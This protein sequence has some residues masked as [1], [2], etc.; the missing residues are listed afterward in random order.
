LIRR[1]IAIAVLEVQLDRLAFSLED[2]VRPPTPF[3]NEAEQPCGTA[4]IPES[5]VPRIRPD[6]R[7]K[8]RVLGH[9][10]N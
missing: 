8:L 9:D 3:V 1:D 7:E 6:R 4:S 10:A 5:D 2:A